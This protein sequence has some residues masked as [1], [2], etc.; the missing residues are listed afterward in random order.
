MTC[1]SSLKAR[2]HHVNSVQ[3]I[4]LYGVKWWLQ[5]YSSQHYFLYVFCDFHII[6]NKKLSD[7]MN[8]FF[9]IEQVHS[10]KW[11]TSKLIQSKVN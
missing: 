11:N 9:F 8:A 5:H 10:H 1:Y 3:C 4:E 6:A 2:S 7:I